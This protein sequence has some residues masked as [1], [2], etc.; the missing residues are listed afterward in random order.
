MGEAAAA[1]SGLSQVSDNELRREIERRGWILVTDEIL[2]RIATRKPH[3][4][5]GLKAA[6][7]RVEH[8][9]YMGNSY[10]SVAAVADLRLLI[11]AVRG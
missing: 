4:P 5:A 9:L 8:R 1:E 11:E 3:R 7:E 6:I 2:M 10:G